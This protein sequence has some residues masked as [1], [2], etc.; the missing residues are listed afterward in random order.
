[1]NP[2]VE[3][4]ATAAALKQQIQKAALSGSLSRF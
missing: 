2:A 1:L 4:V 3:K